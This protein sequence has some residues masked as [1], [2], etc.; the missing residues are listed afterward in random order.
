[1]LQLTSRNTQADNDV[2]AGQRQTIAAIDALM[3]LPATA[4]EGEP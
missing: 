1:M 4:Q 3:A 2:S